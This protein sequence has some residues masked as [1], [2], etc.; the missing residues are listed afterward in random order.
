MTAGD[1]KHCAAPAAGQPD[2]LDGPEVNTKFADD[3][4]TTLRAL[5]ENGCKIGILSDIHFDLR[6]TFV[7]AGLL[8]LIDTFI[9]SY[10]HGIQKPNPAIFELAPSQ[11]ATR[12][13]HTL[14]VGDRPSH[15]GAAATLGIPTLL[16]PTLT[17]SQQ[18]RLHLVT[19]TV[20]HAHTTTT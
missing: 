18:R 9:L 3:V 14:M 13:E 15:D 8:D 12:A 10:E 19:A 20:N 2:G 4:A 11:L 17:E 5:A 6:P 7:D 16:V 1:E